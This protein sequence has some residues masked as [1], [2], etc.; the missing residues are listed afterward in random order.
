MSIKFY[1]QPNPVLARLLLLVLI[2]P[3]SH[4]KAAAPA[5]APATHPVANAHALLV[6][7]TDYPALLNKDMWLHGPANDVELMRAL[8][9]DKFGFSNANI[10]TLKE[11]PDPAMLPTRANILRELNALAA[12]AVNGDKIVVYLSGHGSFQ[13]HVPKPGDFNRETVDGL[14]LP[15]DIG[16]WDGATGEIANALMDRDLSAWIKSLKGKTSSLWLIVDACH[17]GGLAHEKARGGDEKL[18]AVSPEDL[19]VPADLVASA[20]HNVRAK[21]ETSRGAGTP[22]AAL[23]VSTD[24]PGMA[25]VYACCTT[26]QTPECNLPRSDAHRRPYGLF[27]FTLN[28]ILMQSA[29][30]LT[31]SELIRRVNV[32]YT[33]NDRTGQVPLVE[34]AARNQEVLGDEVHRSELRLGRDSS[35]L[36]VNA[37][38]L[39]G[40]HN[41]TI[42]AV[43]PPPGD[44]NADRV[45]GHV[46]VE[47]ARLLYAYVKPCALEQAPLVAAE[48]LVDESVCRPVH[49]EFGIE[50]LTVFLDPSAANRVGA[51]FDKLAAEYRSL[52]SL[53]TAADDAELVV[54][55]KDQAGRFEIRDQTDQS[56]ASGA[57]ASSPSTNKVRVFAV[58]FGATPAVALVDALK[59]VAQARNLLKVTSSGNH[60]GGWGPKVDVKIQMFRFRSKD[61]DQPTPVPWPGN[62]ITLNHGDVVAFQI[63]NQSDQAVDVTVLF[64][65]SRYGIQAVFPRDSTIGD[66]RIGAK[67]SAHTPLITINSAKSF[68][69]EKVVMI[70]VTGGG[71]PKDFTFLAQPTLDV[72]KGARGQATFDTPLGHLF[73]TARY[74]D[75]NTRGIDVDVVTQYDMTIIDWYTNPK[76]P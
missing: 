63:D 71:P 7:V 60:S 61:D 51:D 8:L 10:V 47:D 3:A 55:A 74:G 13:P 27:T 37:G 40:F 16:H 70:A 56:S 4:A 48:S 34:G 32:E 58:P 15:R 68:G 72:P 62:G 54:S 33:A 23:K 14:F 39:H 75:G 35:G 28:K 59:T 26:E 65:D 22:D 31:Y 41:G 30:P 44:R 24:L 67:R 42:F 38:T 76:K 5:T 18:R 64:V 29:G 19:G 20:L 9:R 46:C 6:G 1:R 12:K 25:A 66:N 53:A 49:V 11:G 43:Y 52:F 73:R 45:V 50:P 69:P 21:S 57:S 2:C 36:R 17:S